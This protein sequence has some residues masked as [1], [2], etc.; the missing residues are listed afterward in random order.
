MSHICPSRA[1]AAWHGYSLPLRTARRRRRRHRRRR[2]FM[3]VRRLVRLRR[4]MR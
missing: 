2:L 4:A 3:T 1:D